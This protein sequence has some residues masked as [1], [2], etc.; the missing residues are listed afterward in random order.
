MSCHTNE[1]AKAS[2]H[3]L[4]FSDGYGIFVLKMP[5]KTNK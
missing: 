1:L 3:V 5:Y 4:C 2:E